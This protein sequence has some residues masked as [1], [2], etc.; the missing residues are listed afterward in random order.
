VTADAA[1]QLKTLRIAVTLMR[2][3]QIF[4]FKTK[5]RD[6]LARAKECEA[7]VGRML[8]DLQCAEGPS[9]AS[10]ATCRRAIRMAKILREAESRPFT[11]N[12]TAAPFLGSY[13]P[14]PRIQSAR[15]LRIGSHFPL[16]DT[17]NPLGIQSVFRA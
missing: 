5:S 11:L 10:Q 6:A 1:Y 12:R 4:H 14:T 3:Q 17:S 8:S 2:E 7:R 16:I 9:H 15:L 13:R